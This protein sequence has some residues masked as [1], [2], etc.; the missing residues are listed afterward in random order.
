MYAAGE[1]VRVVGFT[2]FGLAFLGLVLFFVADATV[3]PLQGSKRFTRINLVL[4]IVFVLEFVS[5][6]IASAVRR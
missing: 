1:I 2:G 6:I 4:F 5:M 3:G